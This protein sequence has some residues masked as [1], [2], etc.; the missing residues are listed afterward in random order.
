MQVI[1]ST[2]LKLL[3]C[4]GAITGH[5]D[6]I[7]KKLYDSKRKIKNE[8]DYVIVISTH[9]KRNLS[10]DEFKAIYY[11]ELG[12]F[13]L[14]HLSGHKKTLTESIKELEADMYAVKYTSA[15][16]L[17]SALIKIPS[18]VRKCKSLKKESI[19]RLANDQY[20]EKM[21]IFLSNI[22]MKMQPRYNALQKLILE[23]EYVK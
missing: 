21:N 16:I 23:S 11:H 10:D 22:E 7:A 5:V 6:E 14:G 1:I 17:L 12:H 15:K 4:G 19:N 8:N 13:S 2:N 18:I 9:L 3:R 20:D